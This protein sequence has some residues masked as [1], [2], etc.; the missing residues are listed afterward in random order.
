V[1]LLL[2]THALIWWFLDSPRL[3]HEMKSMIDDPAFT[4]FVSAATA[5]EITSKYRIGRFQEAAELAL[6]LP[7]YVRQ[8]RFEPLPV[9]MEHAHRAGLLPGDH[10][11][12]FDRMLAA[13]A[14]IENAGLVTAD[15]ALAGLGAKVVW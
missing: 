8:W 11:D 1:K 13:Q 6:N 14:I 3:R 5:W 12:P 10:K 15:P 2:D 7:A 9:T 4:I